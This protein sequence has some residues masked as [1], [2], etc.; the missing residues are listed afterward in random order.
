M[1]YIGETTFFY[2]F[3]HSWIW[4]FKP[5][6]DKAGEMLGQKT[7]SLVYWARESP[8]AVSHADWLVSQHGLNMLNQM[9]QIQ[10]TL[11]NSI[12]IWTSGSLWP[13]LMFSGSVGTVLGALKALP[14]SKCSKKSGKEDH[15]IWELVALMCDTFAGTVILIDWVAPPLKA[16]LYSLYIPKLK[17]PFEML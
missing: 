1:S 16:N 12:E 2:L 6:R 10:S 15:T 4:D 3:G 13:K 14:S 5:V 11:N 17:C 7:V 8:L 9:I